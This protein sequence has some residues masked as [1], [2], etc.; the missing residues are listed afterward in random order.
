M[1]GR[2]DV[3]DRDHGSRPVLRWCRIGGHWAISFLAGYRGSGRCEVPGP[4]HG[5][6]GAVRSHG[7][8]GVVAAPLVSQVERLSKGPAAVV[9]GGH[10]R[11]ELPGVVGQVALAPA[12]VDP[13]RIGGIH[14]QHRSLV[15]SFRRQLVGSPGRFLG[16]DEDRRR[17]ERPPSIVGAG[18]KHISRDSSGWV[19]EEPPAQRLSG[20]CHLDLNRLPSME[21]GF[22]GGAR[23]S[24]GRAGSGEGRERREPGVVGDEGHIEG[25]VVGEGNSSQGAV[26]A[27]KR[28]V[29]KRLLHQS[30]PRKPVLSAVGG[31]VHVTGALLVAPHRVALDDHQ[32]AVLGVQG[33]LRRG[34]AAHGIRVGRDLHGLGDN[35]TFFGGRHG[36]Q[37]REDGH[38]ERNGTEHGEFA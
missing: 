31:D 25:S 29:G 38:H 8:G 9:G 11:A 21:E 14:R 17:L 5:V 2:A 12:D 32:L 28:A 27:V 35:R 1:I 7:Q 22:G 37:S 34:V 10:H 36:G 3:L 26:V 30:A 4:K 13:R 24:R 33:N 20:K 16:P 19:G 23:R 15:L 18:E 6:D